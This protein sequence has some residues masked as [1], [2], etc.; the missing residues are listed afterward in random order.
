MLRPSA[1]LKV[2]E[3]VCSC[4]TLVYLQAHK[5]SLSRRQTPTNF[6]LVC[7][8]YGH[9]GIE[10]AR[11]CF[12]V[13]FASGAGRGGGVPAVSC[14]QTVVT[15]HCLCSHDGAEVSRGTL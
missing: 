9:F 4:G 14:G 15:A 8:R 11:P 1:A 2:E 6:V 7:L 13:L 10:G 12:V 3:A 5:V